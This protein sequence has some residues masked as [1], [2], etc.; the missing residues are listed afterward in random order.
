MEITDPAGDKIVVTGLKPPS[1]MQTIPGV[2]GWT[3]RRNTV[4]FSNYGEDRYQ[5]LK[6][7]NDLPTTAD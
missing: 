2:T 5:Q 1:C 6:A 7:W 4:L 3:T